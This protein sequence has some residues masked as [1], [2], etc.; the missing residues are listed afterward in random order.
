MSIALIVSEGFGNGIF[1]GE[2]GKIVTKG[3]TIAEFIPS[4]PATFAVFGRINKSG[5]GV[6]GII[7][8][9]GQGVRGN[10]QGVSNGD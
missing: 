8:P 2:I 10:M 7:D 9:N 5:R 4:D 3:Y 1:V 6:R